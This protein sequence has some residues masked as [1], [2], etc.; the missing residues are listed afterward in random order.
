MSTTATKT[1][2]YICE[3]DGCTG[4]FTEHEAVEGGYCSRE[5]YNRSRGRD[6]LQDIH[7]DHRFC[8]ACFRRKKE[9]E[10]PPESAPSH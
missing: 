9:I 5:C 4:S 2:E 3:A 6:L 7:Q 8:A 1:A 10:K